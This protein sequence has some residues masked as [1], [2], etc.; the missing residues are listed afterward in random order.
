MNVAEYEE[1]EAK[2]LKF[3]DRA[4]IK[5]SRYGIGQVVILKRTKQVGMVTMIRQTE[6]GYNY[7]ISLL[8]PTENIIETCEET[9]KK[10]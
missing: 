4:G 10:Y 2:L 3:C 9:L 6:T 7:E 5:H 1:K 8:A